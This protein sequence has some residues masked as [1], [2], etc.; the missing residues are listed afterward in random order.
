MPDGRVDW[1]LFTL[2]H[3]AE[4]AQLQ[5]GTAMRGYRLRPGVQIDQALLARIGAADTLED[6]EDIRARLLEATHCDARVQDALTALAHTPSVRQAARE[7]G[8]GVRTLERLLRSATHHPPQFWR[9]LARMRQTCHSLAST[10]ALAEV[11]ALHG[12][13]DQSHMNLSFQHWLG[14]TPRQLRAHPERLAL[15][16]AEGYA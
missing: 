14:C 8:V 16:G 4:T 13:A 12:Y 6:E 10:M 5:P 7:L 1:H 15:L 3:R 11:A 9:S 2:A